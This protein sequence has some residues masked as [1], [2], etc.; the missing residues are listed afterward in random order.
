MLQFLKR[1][2]RP[3]SIAYYQLINVAMCVPSFSESDLADRLHKSM[4]LA[5]N[6]TVNADVPKAGA[7][8]IA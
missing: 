7:G 6:M 3:A 1:N 4:V 2:A 5:A 8:M